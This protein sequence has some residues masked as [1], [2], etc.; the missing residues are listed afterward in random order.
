MFRFLVITILELLQF[1]TVSDINNISN[2]NGYGCV[3]YEFQIS[4]TEIPNTLYCLFLNS[5]VG[6]KD[7][8]HLYSPLMSQYCWGGIDKIVDADGNIKYEVKKGFENYPVCGVTWKSAIRFINWLNYNYYKLFSGTSVNIDDLLSETSGDSNSG[9]YNTCNIETDGNIA[10]NPGAVFYLPNRNEWIKSCYYDGIKYK[11]YDT[12]SDSINCYNENGWKYS[13]PHLSKLTQGPKSHYGT[14]NQVGNLGEWVEDNAGYGNNWKLFLGGS[15][16]R[17]SYS[18]KMD[19]QEADEIDKSIASV[20]FRIIKT[21]HNINPS[22]LMPPSGNIETIDVVGACDLKDLNGGIYVRIGNPCNEGDMLNSYRGSVK[23]CFEIS[24]YELTNAEYARFLS[25]NCRN[26]DPFKLYNPHMS[27][28]IIGGILKDTLDTGEFVYYA[29]EGWEKKPVT[30]ISYYSLCRYA[31]WLHYGC[32]NTGVCELGTTEGDNKNGA[33]DTRF[34]EA[35]INGEKRPYRRLT[36]RNRQAKYFIPNDDEWYK[37]AYYDPSL[38]SKYKY[39]LYPT[40]SSTIPMPDDANFMRIDSLT[41]GPPYFVCDVDYFKESASYYGTLNQGGNVWEWIEGWKFGEVG[42]LALRGGSFSYTEFGMSSRNIDSGG[43][44]DVSYVFGARVARVSLFVNGGGNVEKNIFSNNLYCKIVANLKIIIFLFCISIIM[45]IVLLFRKQRNKIFA[46]IKLSINIL[47]WQIRR[48]HFKYNPNKNIVLIVP[49]DPWSVFGS[50]GDEAMLET[51]M[52]Q[53][54]NKETVF[55]YIVASDNA[56]NIVKSKGYKPLK[57]WRGGFPINNILNSIKSVK[58]EIIIILGADCMDGYYSDAVS[59]NLMAIADVCA[60]NTLNYRLTGFSFNQRPKASLFIPYRLST[61]KLKYKLRD[62]VSLN[63]FSKF[64]AKRCELVA[65]VAFLLKP[66]ME[67]TDY[68]LIKEKILRLKS[69]GSLIMGFNYHPML[70]K[71]QSISDS[72]SYA[73]KIGEKLAMILEKDDNL[74]I[75]LIPHDNRGNISDNVVLPLI[76]EKIAS[77]GYADKVY[78]IEKVYHASEI[79]GIVALCDF[80]IC[81]RMHLAIATLSMEIPVIGVK[82]QGKFEGLF[83]HF[84]YPEHYLVSQEDLL[85]DNLMISIKCIKKQLS[86]I[87]ALLHAKLPDIKSLALK[88]FEN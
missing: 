56:A 8:L 41:V 37:A 69:D 21:T 24:K 29:K 67:F 55:Y 46:F 25:S 75:V 33:Y 16:I 11:E 85:S 28:G 22:T 53:Y 44:N 27:T 32:P 82:Y 26:S 81:S 64:S 5:T 60:K 78:Y 43:L 54:Q 50:R 52:A 76:Y 38:L 71:S 45:N 35:V 77:Y 30:Y 83:K 13:F 57:S 9:A 87:R 49:C 18:A 39:H 73:Y 63:I 17:P 20:G 86:V 80:V 15:L 51:V 61:S 72:T 66:N 62:E 23:Y 19:Y 40:R 48:I 59:F 79:K 7:S 10:R 88:N 12:I 84:D 70:Y 3:E 47:I 6:T 14:I 1:V 42:N 2:D 36:K 74:K 68:R 34:F 58:P 4:E 31:N 65:D